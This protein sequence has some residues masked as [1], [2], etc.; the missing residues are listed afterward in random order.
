MSFVAFLRENGVINDDLY[1]IALAKPDEETYICDVLISAGELD[2]EEI[3]V[4]KSKFFK[5]EYTDL[6]SFVLINGFD[7]ASL[8][9]SLVIPFNTSDN[10]VQIAINSLDDLDAKSRL[11]RNIALCDRTK[12]LTPCYYIA[13]KEPNG[14]DPNVV[15]CA[16]A[17]AELKTELEFSEYMIQQ[18]MVKIL[19][20]YN[21]EGE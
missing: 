7:Y 15:L 5:V 18:S 4:L 12:N 9:T 13:S 6:S 17:V 19:S 1:A 14:Y 11:E 3:A 10:T 21:K 8:E 16:K 2:E 20:E